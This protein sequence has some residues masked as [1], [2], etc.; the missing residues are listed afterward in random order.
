MTTKFTMV[1]EQDGVQV[2]WLRT[3][4]PDASTDMA[5]GVDAVAVWM[6]EKIIARGSPDVPAGGVSSPR[7]PLAA[8][9]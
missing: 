7:S 6:K 4:V 9:A 8:E 1:W 5:V 2:E 3:S